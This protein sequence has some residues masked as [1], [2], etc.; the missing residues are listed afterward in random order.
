MALSGSVSRHSI[1]ILQYAALAGKHAD[2][3]I[4]LNS[5]LTIRAETKT[6]PQKRKTGVRLCPVCPAEILVYGISTPVS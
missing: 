3:Y 5:I 4:R 6:T 2:R 1:G